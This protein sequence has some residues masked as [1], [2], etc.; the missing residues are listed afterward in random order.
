MTIGRYR[1]AMDGIP[2]FGPIA[3]TAFPQATAI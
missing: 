2:S 3:R 1:P